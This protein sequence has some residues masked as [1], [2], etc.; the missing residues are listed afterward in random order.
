[1]LDVVVFFTPV[2]KEVTAWVVPRGTPVVKAA[3]KIHSDMEAGFIRAEVIAFERLKEAG[4]W[5]A[6]K[7]KGWVEIKGKDY[8]VRDGDVIVIRFQPPQRR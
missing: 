2:G 4:S 7:E 3:G 6:A 5:D 1:L 8:E